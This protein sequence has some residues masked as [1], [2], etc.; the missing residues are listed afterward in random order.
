MKTPAAFLVMLAIAAVGAM[1]VVR[2]GRAPRMEVS[3]RAAPEAGA[4]AHAP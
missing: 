4:V 3:P 1:A 2:L